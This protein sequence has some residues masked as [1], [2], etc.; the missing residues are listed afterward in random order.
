VP[1]G[2]SSCHQGPR[3]LRDRHVPRGSGSRLLAQASY[4]TAACLVAPAP[5]TRGHGSFGTATCPVAPAPGTGQLRD[6]HVPR[7]QE[8]RYGLLK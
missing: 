7:G 5:A 1:R 4:G 2:S 6:H 8:L 3:Q